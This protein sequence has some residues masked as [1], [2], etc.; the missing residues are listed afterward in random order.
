MT[1]ITI[2]QFWMQAVSARGVG[3]EEPSCVRDCVYM[4][5]AKS[6]WLV[7]VLAAE[8]NVAHAHTLEWGV[9]S[10]DAWKGGGVH[11]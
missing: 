7:D 9:T 11:K 8:Q 3:R 2:L 5:T 6:W 10:E 4:R 1:L